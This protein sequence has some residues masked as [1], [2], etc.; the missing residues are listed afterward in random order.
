MKLIIVYNTSLKPKRLLN[1]F[2]N[3]VLPS[4]EANCKLCDITYSY[5]WK[6]RTWTN[7]LESLSIHHA[8]YFIEGF[9][10]KFKPSPDVTYPCIFLWDEDKKELKTILSALEINAVKDM[11]GLIKSLD[12]KL[13]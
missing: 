2:I 10:K 5:A 13:K 7:Y 8:F 6:K 3:E 12:A 9:E 1:D 11:E 4:R